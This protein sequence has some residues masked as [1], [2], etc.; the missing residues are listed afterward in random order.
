[1]AERPETITE[2]RTPIARGSLAQERQGQNDIARSKPKRR[3]KRKSIGQQSTKRVRPFASSSLRREDNRH[4]ERKGRPKAI[5]SATMIA[6]DG[7]QNQ[8]GLGNQD[9]GAVQDPRSDLI[10]IRSV[11]PTI[12]TG[13]TPRKR[14][15]RKRVSIGQQSKR[16]AKPTMV[17]VKEE[18]EEE[19]GVSMNETTQQHH[20]DTVEQILEESEM[21]EAHL[22]KEDSQ[23][24]N[25][26]LTKPRQMEAAKKTKRKKRKSIGQ[27][28]PRRT[29][30][31]GLALAK[32]PASHGASSK[33]AQITNSKAISAAAET[34]EVSTRANSADLNEDHESS[35]ENFAQPHPKKTRRPPKIVQKASKTITKKTKPRPTSDFAQPKV[36]KATK[37][38]SSKRPIPSNV[39]PITVYRPTT[40]D[41]ASSD[42]DKEDDLPQTA[43]NDTSKTF[44][45]VDVLAQITLERLAILNEKISAQPSATQTHKK[46]LKLYTQ[47]LD[48]RMRQLSRALDTNVAVKAQVKG[49]SKEE[50]EV[51]KELKEVEGERK[52]VRERI[53]E[54]E[55]EKRRWE[56]EEAL[57]RIQEIAR[58]GWE[59]ERAK[60]RGEDPM[61]VRD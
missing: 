37:P 39:I 48:Q 55:R 16:K 35:N 50:R 44:N 29:S 22:G 30:V 46:A 20:P 6:D 19:E 23:P 38:T 33:A 56:L 32:P 4:D 17:I 34:S 31:K 11:E 40:P 18:P 54:L 61:V 10:V 26:D 52:R 51:K 2:V 1:M 28:K 12:G 41:S 53:E 7:A 42:S 15:R 13:F 27:Q 58:K 14:K 8:L 43:M 3:K 57:G 24:R 36:L 9:P 60:E 5:E 45:S 25:D 47:E 59:M 21:V 49:L